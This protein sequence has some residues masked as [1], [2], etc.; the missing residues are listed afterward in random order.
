LIYTGKQSN[1]G[2]IAA[3]DAA[4]RFFKKRLFSKSYASLLFEKKSCKNVV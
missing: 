2:N 4:A 3:A 1:S